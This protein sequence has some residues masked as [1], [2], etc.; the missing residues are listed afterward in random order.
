MLASYLAYER[1]AFTAI[2]AGAE[3]LGYITSLLRLFCR[4][5]APPSVCFACHAAT[6]AGGKTCC[7]A[8]PILSRV[9]SGPKNEAAIADNEHIKVRILELFYKRLLILNRVPVEIIM[10]RLHLEETGVTSIP[11]RFRRSVPVT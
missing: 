7:A 1:V 2:N 10:H 3:S 5:E 6:T 11:S 4:L 8:P 9:C